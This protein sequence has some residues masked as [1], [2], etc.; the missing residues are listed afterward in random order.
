MSARDRLLVAAAAVAATLAAAAGGEARQQHA[1]EPS[2]AWMVDGTVTTIAPT[3]AG[4]FVG[5][6]F[7]LI[8]RPT[9]SWV[10]VDTAGVAVPARPFVEGGVTAVADDG[11]GGWFLRGSELTLDGTQ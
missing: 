1:G 7:S 6:D 8:G 10:E 3:A 5:G 4:V 9:G 11:A 2:A